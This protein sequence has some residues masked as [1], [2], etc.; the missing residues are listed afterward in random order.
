MPAVPI[1]RDKYTDIT[2]EI[3]ARVRLQSCLFPLQ[4]EIE[5]EIIK[6]A[7]TKSAAYVRGLR[8]ALEKIKE[9]RQEY[10]EQELEL[11]REE[12]QIKARRQA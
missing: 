1:R 2:F 7:R 5:D 8:F 4:R 3:L 10:R 6:N 12:E 11:L 9:H